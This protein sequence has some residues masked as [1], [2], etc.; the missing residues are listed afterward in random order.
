MTIA[1][2]LA[3]ARWIDARTFEAEGLTFHFEDL[4]A[5]ANERSAVV[6]K[7]RDFF[8]AY[9]EEIGEDPT[10]RVLEFGVWRGGSALALAAFLTPDKLVALDISPPVEEFDLLRNSHPLGRKIAVRYETSQDDQ[11]ALDA[12]V[13]EEF[14]G[15]IDLVIDDAS[16]QYAL[17]KRSFEIAFRHVRDGGCYVIEDWAWA[18]VQGWYLNFEQPALTNL[19]VRLTILSFCRPD[20]IEKVV[21]RRQAVFVKK[22]AGAGDTGVLDLDAMCEMGGRPPLG[23]M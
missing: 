13:A 21:V 17:S 19:I 18:H 10:E 5:G 11:A 23:L 3:Q 15:P 14:D 1:D 16:H 9:A 20:L 8:E 4:P 7:T 12:L 2:R 6:M 22:A